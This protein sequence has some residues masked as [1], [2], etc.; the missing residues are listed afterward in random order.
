VLDQKKKRV[1]LVPDGKCD[2]D[3]PSA[4]KHNLLTPTK[5]NSITRVGGKAKG[6]AGASPLW[7]QL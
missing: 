4:L 1:I 3:V 7:I 2:A 6:L 5:R